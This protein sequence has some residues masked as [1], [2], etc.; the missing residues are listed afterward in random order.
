MSYDRGCCCDDLVDFSPRVQNKLPGDPLNLSKGHGG[1][2][3]PGSE[4]NPPF[5]E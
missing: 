2:K 3:C 1:E 5:V 4:C